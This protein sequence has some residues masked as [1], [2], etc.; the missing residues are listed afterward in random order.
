M[1]DIV[2]R[3]R[4]WVYT[5]SQ[6]ATAR[7]AA[8]EIER[9]RNG[10]VESRETVSHPAIL[11]DYREWRSK[12]EDRIG[13]HSDRC[14]LWP[15]HERC[16]IHRLAEELERLSASGDC[17]VSDNETK[18]DIQPLAAGG[19]AAIRDGGSGNLRPPHPT[20]VRSS[21]VTDDRPAPTAEV[22]LLQNMTTLTPVE[23]CV[24]R[25]VRHGYADVDDVRCNEI[26]YVIDRLLAR[27]GGPP[28][29][30]TGCGESRTG[31]VA[32]KTREDEAKCTVKS[33]KLPERD[34]KP[35][36][37]LA[38]AGDASESMAVFLSRSDADVAA[39]DYGGWFVVPLYRQPQPTL[40]DEERETVEV[41]AE[42][43]A[44]DHGER[45]AATLRALLER[46]GGG[47]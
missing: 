33:K 25:E 44:D 24:L 2:E 37:W 36:A 10:A 40:T 5:D 26:A 21:P 17:P 46:L 19:R 18:Q 23:R 14:H 3:L 7:E 6:Y 22:F 30:R 43:Y 31:A 35:L 34:R 29:P 4:A 41:A 38:I 8:D 1:S 12:Q 47:E 15:R 11:A 27:L 13:T 32:A 45:F 42:A 9:L 20:P 28:I 39:S 16:M